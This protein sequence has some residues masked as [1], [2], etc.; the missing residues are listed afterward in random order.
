MRLLILLLFSFQAYAAQQEI[1]W[2]HN[3]KHT[4]HFNVWGSGPNSVQSDLISTVD[5]LERKL[6]IN[7]P[8]D[9]S[10][11]YVM[12]QA[13]NQELCSFPSQIRVVKLA[14]PVP[15]GVKW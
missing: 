7:I 11:L 2:T 6:T 5:R 9:C 15:N 8:D 13:C 14:C 1:S 12:I 4:T 10:P 3:G